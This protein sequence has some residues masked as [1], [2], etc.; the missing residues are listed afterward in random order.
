MIPIAY[1]LLNV[2]HALWH[3]Y[4]IVKKNIT[5][6]STQKTIEYSVASILAAVVLILFHYPVL[7]MILFALLTRMAFFDILLN[8]LRGKSWLYEGEI[9]KRKSWV[10]WFENQTGLPIWVLRILYIA[11]YIGYLIIYLT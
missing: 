2:I 1:I 9:K 6:R 4:R 8:I 11:V 7:P 10:D 3:W 5:I